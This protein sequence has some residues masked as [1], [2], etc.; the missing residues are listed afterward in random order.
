[1]DGEVPQDMQGEQPE[2]QQMQDPIQ[3]AQIQQD[4]AFLE[5]QAANLAEVKRRRKE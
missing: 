5:A 4:E 2:H 3:E 1:M